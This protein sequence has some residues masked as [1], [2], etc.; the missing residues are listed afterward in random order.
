VDQCDTP[1]QQS[2]EAKRSP[3]TPLWVAEPYYRVDWSRVVIN[4]IEKDDL[5]GEAQDFDVN[6]L[7]GSSPISNPARKG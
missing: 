7:R 1:V 6:Q 5:Q 4:L 2:D 3:F